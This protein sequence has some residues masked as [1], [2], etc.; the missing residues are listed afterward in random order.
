MKTREHP[1]WATAS[2]AGA[3]LAAEP[4]LAAVPFDVERVR[5][6]SQAERGGDDRSQTLLGSRSG[7]EVLWYRAH[8]QEPHADD[9][10]YVVLDGRGGVE[11]EGRPVPSDAA[12]R[13]TFPPGATRFT[14]YEQLSVLVIFAA[15]GACS[16]PAARAVAPQ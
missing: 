14:A 2:A 8:R 1:E 10:V 15:S 3:T 12:R 6:T 5:K 13:S 9:E 7:S 11:V 16:R 4:A